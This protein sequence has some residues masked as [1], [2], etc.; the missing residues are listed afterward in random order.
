M[1][2][3]YFKITALTDANPLK[4][5][6]YDTPV[7][8]LLGHLR[9]KFEFNKAADEFAAKFGDKVKPLVGTNGSSYYL[10]GLVFDGQPEHP[11]LW[12]KP[13]RKAHFSQ[14]PRAKSAYNIKGHELKEAHKKLWE[15]WDTK[16]ESL[17]L[18]DQWLTAGYCAIDLMIGGG[19]MA[20]DYEGDHIYVA[21]SQPPER[22]AEWEEITG[23]EY[24]RIKEAVKDQKA[25]D[26][27]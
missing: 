10:H 21:A 19:Q 9:D 22:G 1:T 25:E 6:G 23:G 7:E 26:Y 4:E 27:L 16:P 2:T 14:T 12:L 17:D 11:E 18:D 8:A 24:Q 5:R 3:R 20:I 15:K 13:N